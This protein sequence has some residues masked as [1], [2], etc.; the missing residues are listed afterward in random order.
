MS[1]FWANNK[2]KMKHAIINNDVKIEDHDDALI[3]DFA[4]KYIGGGALN[5]GLVQEEILFLVFT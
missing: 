2:M 1:T 4:N 5:T 3:A